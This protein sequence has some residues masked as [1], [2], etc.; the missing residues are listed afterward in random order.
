MGRLSKQQVGSSPCLPEDQP[1]AAELSEAVWLGSGKPKRDPVPGVGANQDVSRSRVNC[2]AP[3]AGIL[4]CTQANEIQSMI[5][6]GLAAILG[7]VHENQGYGSQ[8]VP[9][10]WIVDLDPKVGVIRS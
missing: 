8:G 7:A 2:Q 6:N 4:A 10:K 1:D 9:H 3:Y 5:F